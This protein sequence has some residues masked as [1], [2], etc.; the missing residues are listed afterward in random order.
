MAGDLLQFDVDQAKAL[1][2]TIQAK[3]N[4]ISKYLNNIGGLVEESV[5]VN[6][7]GQ[8]AQRFVKLFENSRRKAQDYLKA[9]ITDCK[10]FI[11]EATKAKLAMEEAEKSMLD[12]ADKAL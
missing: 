8:S 1:E 10:S 9:Y 6:W 4:E 5:R 11:N 3:T 2:K 7:S 12:Q